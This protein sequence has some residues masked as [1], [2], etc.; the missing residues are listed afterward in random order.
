MRHLTTT[1]GRLALAAALLLAAAPRPAH[2]QLGKFIRKAKSAAASAT[3]SSRDDGPRFDDR[4]LEL[5]P[6][7]LTSVVQGIR[8]Q[9]HVL[10]TAGGTGV[11]AMN[12][13]MEAVQKRAAQLDAQ[14]TPAQHQAANRV[15][16]AHEDCIHDALEARQRQDAAALQ[17]AMMDPKVSQARMA[18]VQAAQTGDTAAVRRANATLRDATQGIFHK[19][20]VAAQ[21]ACPVSANDRPMVE[22]DSLTRVA[23]RLGGDIRTVTDSA[24]EAGIRAS[25]LDR[26]QYGMARE[27]LHYYLLQ[28]ENHWPHRGFTST[29]LSALAARE[30]ELRQLQASFRGQGQELW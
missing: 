24:E 7:R 28:I 5:S 21:H 3:G 17:A 15:V 9:A 30:A 29:E 11:G 16:Q 10:S 8:A 22:Q 2:A 19:D 23:N 1:P 13:R 27:R 6:A 12:A 18:L 20:T 4:T 25:G 26:D 14:M